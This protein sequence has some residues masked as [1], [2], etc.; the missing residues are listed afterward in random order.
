MK[1][2]FA[3]IIIPLLVAVGIMYSPSVVGQEIQERQIEKAKI[4]QEEY[5]LISDSDLYC[6]IYSIEKPTFDIRIIAGEQTG[7]KIL[8]SDA[9]VLYIDR[10]KQDG[11]EVGQMFLVLNIG[12]K[13]PGRASSRDCGY[14][15]NRRGKVR[16]AR[17]EENRAIVTVEKAC[18]PML[19]GDFLVPYEE[20]ETVFGKDEGFDVLL[21]EG[22]GLNGHIAYLD[23]DYIIVGSGYW[24]II[25]LGSDD[26]LKLGQQLTV[27]KRVKK[28]V[29]R[30]AI[31]NIVVIDVQP[32]TAT[33]KV[34]SC[35]DPIE[36]GYQVQ[37]K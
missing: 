28:D 23:R 5:A 12:G 22:A 19:V 30:Q 20:R 37:S 14:L 27:F 2:S 1:K 36:E 16:I 8:Q 17:L 34:L 6:S 25:D 26:G 7:E 31:G 21:E 15:V 18:G 10:G 4:F 35:R 11:L 3:W 33:V 9:D 13:I 24:A 29:P 32:K